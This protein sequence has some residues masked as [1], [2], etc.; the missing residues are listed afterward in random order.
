MTIPKVLCWIEAT[1]L[2]LFQLCDMV[3]CHKKMD[4]LSNK[5]QA[6]CAKMENVSHHYTTSPN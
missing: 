4:M 2:E 1:G 5:T 6:E 3:C